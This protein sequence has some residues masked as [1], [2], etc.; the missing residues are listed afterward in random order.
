MPRS[1][2]QIY[3]DSIAPPLRIPRCPNGN[4]HVAK[5]SMGS[6]V[7][8]NIG[9][10]SY[11]CKAQNG[12]P[13]CRRPDE[14]WQPEHPQ[15]VQDKLRRSLDAWDREQKA[16]QALEKLQKAQQ[17]VQ[18]F[19]AIVPQAREDADHHLTPTTPRSDA[20]EQHHVLVCV[21][22]WENEACFEHQAQLSSGS[23]AL[24]NDKQLCHVTGFPYTAY[25]IYDAFRDRF[26]PLPTFSSM[27]VQDHEF[28]ILRSSTLD[29]EDCPDLR[30][31][32]TNLRGAVRQSDRYLSLL[33]NQPAAA[34][35]QVPLPT[36]STTTS[37]SPTK[38][39]KRKPIE[40]DEAAVDVAFMHN[41]TVM[42]V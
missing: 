8:H 36:P 5:L 21:Y 27:E 30:R 28:L 31:L 15:E 10:R 34:D 23:Y 38:L 13:Q 33:S 18:S 1:A 40:A 29:D 6:K 35:V 25:S 26:L 12:R 22:M 42:T 11:M 19:T 37:D 2:R 32:I 17:V 41:T 16:G 20:G 7:P 9:R 3:L 4:L 24:F 39:G 14:T